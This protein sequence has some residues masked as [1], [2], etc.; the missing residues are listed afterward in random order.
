MKLKPIENSHL[1]DCADL[2]ASVF[3]HPPWNETWSPEIALNRLQDCYDTPGSYGVV[4]IAEY[5]VLGFAIGHAETW[6]ENKHFYLKEM[7]VQSTKQRSGIGTKIMDMLYQDLSSKDVSM[8]YLLTARDSP[9]V[10]FYKNYG[11]SNSSKMTMM[12]KMVK[13]QQ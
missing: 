6:H 3:S 10:A 13:T 8:V 12:L 1:R 4:A 5:K 2:F 7:C 9:A 11:F